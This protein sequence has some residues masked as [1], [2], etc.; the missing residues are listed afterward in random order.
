MFSKLTIG[1]KLFIISVI[2]GIW[3]AATV[4]L[5][6]SDAMSENSKLKK[7][8][9]LVEFSAKISLLVHETQKERGMS[10]GYLGSKGKKFADKLPSQRAL[11]DNRIKELKKFLNGFDFSDYSPEIKEKSEQ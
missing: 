4:L 5:T 9:R 6:I 1:T 7:L 3:G 8:D 11:T 2:I 10:A